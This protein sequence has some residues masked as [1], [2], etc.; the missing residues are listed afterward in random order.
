MIH[1]SKNKMIGNM[2]SLSQASRYFGQVNVNNTKG[3]M[4]ALFGFQ[5]MVD[6]VIMGCTQVRFIASGSH[7]H[8]KEYG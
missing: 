5:H 4:V 1:K 6:I 7:I 2:N 8:Q 3:Y